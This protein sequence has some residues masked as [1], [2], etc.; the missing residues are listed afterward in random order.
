MTAALAE[1]PGVTRVHHVHIWATST[2][3]TALTAHLVMPAGPPGDA[4]LREVAHDL[5]HR[6]AIGHST[7]QVERG[8]DP[9]CADC[10]SPL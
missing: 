6:F 3:A 5:E 9:D 2:T 1:V 7:F 4:F 10:G 8:S